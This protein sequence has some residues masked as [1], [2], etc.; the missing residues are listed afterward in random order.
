M[1]CGAENEANDLFNDLTAN[2]E[3]PL[4]D[5]DLGGD[6]FQLPDIEGSA[7]YEQIKKLKNEDLVVEDP[8]S[9]TATFNALMGGF[10][11]YL[12]EEFK[13]SRIT[14]A[15]YSKTFTA[16]TEG[17]MANAV[18]F[19][20]GRDASL[21]QS[22][23]A[24]IQAVTARVDLEAA[25][26]KLVALQYEANNRKAEFALTKMKLATESAQFCIAQFN[27]N[28]MLPAQLSMVQSQKVG[29]D[30]Q[31][32]TLAY[33]LSNILPQQYML[34]REQTEV[35]RSQTSDS[36]TD[37]LPVYG[38]VGK[39]KELY[40]QQITS[41]KRDSETKVAKLF[42]DAWITQKTIDEGLQAPNGFTNASLDQILAVLKS[43]NGLV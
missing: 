1:S 20:L 9:S 13:K 8:K 10:R 19:L 26:A 27:L 32:D 2:T 31:N 25:K 33:T 15:E 3:F 36:R 22:I 5:V 30:R 43:N 39:Q 40:S 23:T 34:L 12:E 28:S 21:W 42:T 17:A 16:L 41:Y 11:G 35:Q 37:G 18:Q 14:G 4:P 38:S 29:Q 7:L 6:E 24:Q